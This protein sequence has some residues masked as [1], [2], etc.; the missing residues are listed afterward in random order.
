MELGRELSLT[1]KT[2]AERIRKLRKQ[3]IILGFRPSVLARNMGYIS[4]LFL[5]KYHNISLG[6]D[7]FAT[8]LKNHPNI[9]RA[10]KTIGE[11]DIEIQVEVEN[12]SEL[13]NVEM[14]IREKFSSLIK[15]IANVPLYRTYKKTFFP[16]FLVG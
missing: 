16:G 3:E 14:E 8:Y 5:I 4:S 1:P 10:V 2:V 6:G 15:E 7:E 11:W 9:V 13:R 12:V